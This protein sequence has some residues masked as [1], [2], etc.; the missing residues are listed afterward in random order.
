MALGQ[1]DIFVRSSGQVEVWSNVIP[2]ADILQPSVILLQV[3]LTFGQIFGSGWS[4]VRCPHGWGFGSSW[5]LGRLWNR[6]TFSSDVP[7]IRDMVWPSSDTTS[8]QVDIWSDLWVR[9]TFGQTY[10]QQVRLWSGWHLVRVWDRLTCGQMYPQA[11]TSCGQVW[12][13]NRSGW[14]LLRSSGQD[15]LWSDISPRIRLQVRLTFSEALGQAELC[16]DVPPRWCFG[17]GLHLVRLQVSMTF[18]EMSGPW[19]GSGWHFVR[20]PRQPVSYNWPAWPKVWPDMVQN[21]FFH[22]ISCMWL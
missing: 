9:V 22:S 8:D 6:L 18:G 11:E 2:Q 12:Y 21:S 19:R 20:P 16:S 1:G 4:L 7:P 13:Y 10:P 14:H 15:D 5:H 17:L 3:R